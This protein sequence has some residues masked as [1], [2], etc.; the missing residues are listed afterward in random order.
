[1]SHLEHIRGERIAVV[2]HERVL[3]G[4]RR[5]TQEQCAE[6]TVREPENDAKI[7]RPQ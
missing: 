3:H 2:P 1:M 4:T 7:V 6:P 5:I